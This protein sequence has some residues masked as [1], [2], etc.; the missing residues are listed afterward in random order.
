MGFFSFIIDA[1]TTYETKRVIRIK[2]KRVSLLNNIT[3]VLIL[4]V[5]GAIIWFKIFFVSVCF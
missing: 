5:I 2:R 1:L 3:R 4:F